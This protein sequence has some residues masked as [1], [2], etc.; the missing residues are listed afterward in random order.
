MSARLRQV[1]PLAYLFLGFSVLGVISELTYHFLPP[2]AVPAFGSWVASLSP[3]DH[4]FFYLAW[5][6]VAH[7][8]IAL[9]LMGMVTVVV[10][11]NLSQA[12]VK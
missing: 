4:D 1:P 10:Y 3:E 9:G 7:M 12:N 6:L 8:C 5:E 11:R 2:A